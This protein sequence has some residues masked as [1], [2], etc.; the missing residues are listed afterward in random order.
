MDAP[1]NSELTELLI[2]WS[3]GDEA[4]LDRL[5]P[6][7]E[8]ELRRIARA[9]MNRESPGHTLQPTA[10]VNEAYL[11]LI[12]QRDVKWQNRAHFFAIAARLM[13]RVLLDHARA[14]HRAKRGG[15]AIQISLT[16]VLFENTHKSSDLIKLD[17]A[18]LELA[19]VDLEKSRIVEMSYFGGLTAEEIAPVC[20]ISAVTVRRHLKFAR[21]WL[22]RE[23]STQ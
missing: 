11:K 4:A 2:T 1:E 9:Q 8:R 5:L 7:V 19:K 12:N 21:A 6:L 10:L 23:M 15:Q 22:K 17:E 16:N 20:G 14:Q 18:L 13:R 3:N